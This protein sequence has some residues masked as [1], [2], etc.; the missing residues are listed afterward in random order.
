MQ[1]VCHARGRRKRAVL[2]RRH[3]LMRV[4]A[5]DTP[6]DRLRTSCAAIVKGVRRAR[7]SAPAVVVA[8]RCADLHSWYY[9]AAIARSESG[10]SWSTPRRR[11]ARVLGDADAG[12]DGAGLGHALEHRDA[13]ARAGQ[14]ERGDGTADRTADDDDVLIVQ[15]HGVRRFYPFT[16]RSARPGPATQVAL[17]VE[18]TGPRRSALIT[19]S[20]LAPSGP[21]RPVPQAPPLPP[22]PAPRHPACG[23]R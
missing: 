20:P 2:R 8:N 10:V 11:P 19:A 5:T 22:V 15:P 4:L 21:A 1:S 9:G 13:P 14:Q 16:G 6:V 3:P 12:A 17:A 23:H 18:A 7:V